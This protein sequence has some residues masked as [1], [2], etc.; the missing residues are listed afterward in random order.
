ME[1]ETK[2]LKKKIMGFNQQDIAD[3]SKIHTKI[4][5]AELKYINEKIKN[6]K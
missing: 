6:E 2:K 3:F 4:L 5:E 1:K